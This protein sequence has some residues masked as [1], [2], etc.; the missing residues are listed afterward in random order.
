VNLFNLRALI[1][2]KNL[3]K[4]AANRMNQMRPDNPDSYDKYRQLNP[5]EQYAIV[6]TITSSDSILGFQEESRFFFDDDNEQPP[7][8]QQALSDY[9]V[10]RSLQPNTSAQQPRL[11]SDAELIRQNDALEIL[12]THEQPDL[13]GKT[14]LVVK[15]LSDF[16]F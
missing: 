9:V 11:G 3:K 16:S 12:Q 5:F 1:R 15:H 8:R 13:L 6:D 7:T 10:K 4:I 2:L 14:G